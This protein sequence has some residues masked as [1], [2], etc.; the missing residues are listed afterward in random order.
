MTTHISARL[1]WHNNGWNGRICKDPKANTYCVGQYSFPGDMIAKRRDLD[2][3]MEHSGESSASFDEYIPPCIWSCN[4][5]GDKQL[6]TY[7][8]PPSWFNDGTHTKKWTLPPYTIC[9]WP[10]EEMYR[11][12]VRNYSKQ[13][14]TTKYNAIARREAAN[15]YFEQIVPQKSLIFYYANYSNPFS[16]NDMHQ[17]VIVGISR[18]KEVGPEITW[19]NQSK[20]MEDRYGPNVWARN[21]TSDFP[22]QGLRIPYELYMDAPDILEQILFVPENARDFKFATRHFSDD[23]ALGL[24]ERLSEIVGNLQA[25]GDTSENWDIRQD[26]LAS[27][28]AELWSERGLYPGLLTVLD[29]LQVSVSF[30]L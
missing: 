26:W 2:F 30:F 8:P 29:F 1:A 3:E 19:D 15:Q 7:N 4:A 23:R 21:I 18:I 6:I 11:D 20:K 22:D 12:E 13:K 10:Y 16:E 9:V 24:I 17:Y 25:I 5:F 28:M 27:V 14:G